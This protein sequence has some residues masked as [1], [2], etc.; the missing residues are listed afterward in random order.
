[1]QRKILIINGSYRDDGLT[2]QT[3]N[4]ICEHLRKK[5]AKI[6][7]IFLRKEDFHFCLNCR[8]CM[9]KTGPNP[10]P[11][12]QIDAMKIIVE[13]LEHADAYVFASPTNLGSVTALFKR[14]MERL[15]V[16]AYWPWGAASPKYR[17]DVLPKKERKKALLVSSSA[18]PGIL[19]RWFFSTIR[20]LKYTARIIG[21]NPIGIINNGLIAM[22]SDKKL[23]SK[24]INK[25]KKQADKLL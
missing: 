3:I 14:F 1:M 22:S 21:A 13:K 15:S 7:A 5:G 10:E 19:S 8:E 6:D 20:Q 12:I 16:Y 25:I 11:C 18:A 23:N 24:D 2:D 17:K 9:Q 4:I